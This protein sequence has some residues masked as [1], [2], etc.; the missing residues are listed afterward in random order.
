[1]RLRSILCFVIYSAISCPTIYVVVLASAS[2]FLYAASLL[3]PN[4]YRS[5]ASI[6]TGVSVIIPN[7]SS[8]LSASGID[9]WMAILTAAINVSWLNILMSLGGVVV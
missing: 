5:C 8:A 7:G 3:S 6:F 9:V 4:S 2:S 1:M